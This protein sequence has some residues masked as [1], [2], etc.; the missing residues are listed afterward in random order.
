MKSAEEVGPQQRD[1]YQLKRRGIKRKEDGAS[2]SLEPK[3]KD[4]L[5]SPSE[6]SRASACEEYLKGDSGVVSKVCVQA[7]KASK[8][9]GQTEGAKTE[10]ALK[11]VR[12]RL[13][14]LMVKVIPAFIMFKDRD[15]TPTNG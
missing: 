13:N 2:K 6:K 10:G 11:L 14:T 8:Q 5:G 4:R 12:R 7:N 3:Q 9:R 1:D 15:E